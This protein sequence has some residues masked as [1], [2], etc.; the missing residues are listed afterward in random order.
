MSNL[1]DFLYGKINCF[2]CHIQINS[3]Q[4]FIIHDTDAHHGHEKYVE[5]DCRCAPKN[6]AGTR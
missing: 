1:L 6:K 2:S 4:H 3:L 5:N